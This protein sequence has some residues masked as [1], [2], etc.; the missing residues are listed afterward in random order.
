MTLL[1]NLNCYVILLIL[2]VLSVSCRT[3]GAGMLT[4]SRTPD[5]TPFGEFMISPI[6]SIYIAE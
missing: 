2:L 3:C 6:Q 1:Y 5:F 4:L